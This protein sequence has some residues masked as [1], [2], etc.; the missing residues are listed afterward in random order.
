MTLFCLERCSAP[1]PKVQKGKVEGV[2]KRKGLQ[3]LFSD[4]PGGAQHNLWAALSKKRV[5][6]MC[7]EIVAVVI[8]ITSTPDCI[9]DMNF[10]KSDL[11]SCHPIVLHSQRRRC[12]EG[13]REWGTSLTWGNHSLQ[14]FPLRCPFSAC[15][16]DPCPPRPHCPPW[17]GYSILPPRSL[18]QSHCCQQ[19]ALY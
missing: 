4:L 3:V 16:D 10:T 2:R 6:G 8:L 13:G 12:R 17:R 1:K 5:L 7:L 19:N 9:I 14:D 18:F 15:G 11:P